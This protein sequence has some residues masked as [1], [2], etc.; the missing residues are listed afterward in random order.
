MTHT[1]DTHTQ[2]RPR[3]DLDPGLYWDESV[4]T[5]EEVTRDL[6]SWLE[7]EGLWSADETDRQILETIQPDPVSGL[8]R[9]DLDPEIWEDLYTDLETV[10]NDN[11]PEGLCFGYVNE[12]G[13]WAVIEITEEDWI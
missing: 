12:S 9:T 2:D 13:G 1:D 5:L 11:L 3:L 6:A 10:V 7:D 4:R 8:Y